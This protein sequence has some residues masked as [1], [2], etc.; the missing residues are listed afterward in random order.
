MKGESM[1]TYDQTVLKQ[2]LNRYESVERTSDETR[3]HVYGA[4]YQRPRLVAVLEYCFS[5]G[6][7]DAIEIGCMGGGTSKVL[8]AACQRY[9]RK[10]VCVDPWKNMPG[11]DWI[12]FEAHYPVFLKVMR[13][14]MDVIEIIKLP[15]QDAAAIAMIQ[16]HEYAFAFVDGDHAYQ[17]ALTDLH[18][19][20]PLVTCAVASDDHRYDTRVQQA[21]LEAAAEFTDWSFVASDDLREAWFLK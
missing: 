9:G 4:T 18:T 13:P 17:P 20:L 16:Q 11:Y 6:P 19:V 15:S 21:N 12:D 3:V 7:G 5:C 2:L 10:L 14:Y 1:R 8:A